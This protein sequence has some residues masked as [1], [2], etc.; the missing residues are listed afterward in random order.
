MFTDYIY[1]NMI[2]KSYKTHEKYIKFKKQNIYGYIKEL[3]GSQCLLDIVDNDNKIEKLA[4]IREI[5]LI[6]K[7]DIPSDIFKILKYQAEWEWM[8]NYFADIMD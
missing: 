2:R 8:E 6:D 3:T 4:D 7:K 5:E 1:I